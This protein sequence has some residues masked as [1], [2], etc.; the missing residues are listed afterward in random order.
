MKIFKWYVE[1]TQYIEEE[2]VKK[3]R[4]MVT[5]VVFDTIYTRIG[6]APSIVSDD[7]SSFTT[8]V[9]QNYLPQN[10]IECIRSH[11]YHFR[12]A[13]GSVK[14]QVTKKKRINPRYV[15]KRCSK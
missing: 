6:L 2:G 11:A 13:S 12:K 7:K 4:C 9:F 5:I 1:C 14:H 3:I 15:F 8:E 10:G